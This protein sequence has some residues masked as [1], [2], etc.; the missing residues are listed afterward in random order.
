MFPSNC[1]QMAPSLYKVKSSQASKASYFRSK[2]LIWMH[3]STFRVK[4]VLSSSLRQMAFSQLLITAPQLH[5]KPQD[6]QGCSRWRYLRKLE[7]DH[8]YWI[9]Y[10][11]CN[12][13]ALGE[14]HEHQWYDNQ[15]EQGR[16]TLESFGWL[17]GVLE[18]PRSFQLGIIIAKLLKHKYTIF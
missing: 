11:C 2:I 12:F 13:L 3:S 17:S 6:S 8:K 9:H 18:I 7:C 10:K 4:N 5:Y 1:P 14:S 16:H 15:M